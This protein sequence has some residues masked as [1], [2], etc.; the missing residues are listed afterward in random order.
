MLSASGLRLWLITLTSTLII[1]DI[2]KTSSNNCLLWCSARARFARARSSATTLKF[3]SLLPSI[4]GYVFLDF[5]VLLCNTCLYRSVHRHGHHCHSSPLAEVRIPRRAAARAH[6]LVINKGARSTVLSELLYN[7]V[8][9]PNTFFLNWKQRTAG[10]AV[11][12]ALQY[13]KM[14]VAGV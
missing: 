10:K 11:E 12:D 2:T 13:I 1:P 6:F 5:Y 4:D 7:V 8:Y 9:N 14:Y 3:L